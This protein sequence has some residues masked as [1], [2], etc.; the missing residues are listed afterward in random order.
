MK[1]LLL[2]LLLGIMVIFS[3]AQ[4]TPPT[5]LYKQAVQAVAAQDFGQ[6]VLALRRATLLAPRDA[7]LQ[8]AL[9]SVRREIGTDSDNL[10]TLQTLGRL[11]SQLMTFAELSIVVWSVWT[12]SALMLALYISRRTRTWWLRG[13]VLL[14][15]VIAAS[16]AILLAIRHQTEASDAIVMTTTVTR[17]GPALD[18]LSLSEIIAGSEINILQTKDNWVQF[19][20]QDGSFGWLPTQVIEVVIPRG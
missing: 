11:T 16:G 19:V 4:E 3:T 18:Y 7:A 6:A 2:V 1:H 14:L 15:L 9:N 8:A 13:T 12:F 5:D 10:F 20:A 17:T